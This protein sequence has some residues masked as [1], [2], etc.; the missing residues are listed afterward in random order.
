MAWWVGINDLKGGGLT[1][2]LLARKYG[3]NLAKR[4]V[5]NSRFVVKVSIHW[6][7]MTLGFHSENFTV[8]QIV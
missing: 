1:F 2:E 4:G 3:M 6:V 5:C 8:I 7:V